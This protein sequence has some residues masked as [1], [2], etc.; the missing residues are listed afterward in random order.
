MRLKQQTPSIQGLFNSRGRDTDRSLVAVAA[1]TGAGDLDWRLLGRHD[2]ARDRQDACSLWNRQ[3]LRFFTSG[4]KRLDHLIGPGH[5]HA[6][7]LTEDEV[8]RL[9]CEVDL[10]QP[11]KLPQGDVRLFE[12]HWNAVGQSQPTQPHHHL[13]RLYL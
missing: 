2:D 4:R 11:R 7:A 8:K 13:L 5:A 9:F 6:E 12:R 3:K 1:V 10:M